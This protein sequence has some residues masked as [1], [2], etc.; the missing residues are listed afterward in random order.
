MMNKQEQRLI[1]IAPKALEI[2]L[3]GMVQDPED[4]DA[5]CNAESV[6]LAPT[7]WD[8][9]VKVQTVGEEWDGEDCEFSDYDSA[10]SFGLKL[11]EIAPRDVELQ[12]G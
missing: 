11:A 3:I 1:D 9:F 7:S 12:V 5:Y 4:S 6:D 8:I 2:E 10:Y